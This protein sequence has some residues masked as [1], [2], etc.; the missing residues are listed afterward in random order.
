M[1]EAMP[2]RA[3]P[4]GAHG[5]ANRPLAFSFSRIRFLRPE[6]DIQIAGHAMLPP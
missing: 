1:T 5:M 6:L 3:L 2:L 4:V